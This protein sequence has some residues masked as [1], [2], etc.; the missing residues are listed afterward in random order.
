V[1]VPQSDV[2]SSCLCPGRKTDNGV[3]RRSLPYETLIPRRPIR[4]RKLT[5]VGAKDR[6]GKE[7]IMLDVAFV[8][9]GL[10]VLALMGVYALALRQL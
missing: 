2:A 5:W 4:N 7:A 9:L 6:F 3:S 8:A 1:D 10:A